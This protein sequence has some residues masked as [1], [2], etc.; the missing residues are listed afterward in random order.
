MIIKD[1]S[2]WSYIFMTSN[3]ENKFRI[4]DYQRPYVRDE[5]R[6]ED[7]LND[8]LDTENNLPFLWSFIFQTTED[9]YLD[10]V[11]GQQR[12]MSITILLSLLRNL[13][14]ELSQDKLAMSIQQR[15]TKTDN[16]WR[17][18]EFF[19]TC[20][21]DTQKFLVENILNEDW[22]MRTYNDRILKKD[23]S[24]YNIKKN[25][26]T[27]YDIILERME[28]LNDIQKAELIDHILNRLDKYQIVYIQVNNDEEAYTAFEIV[29]ARWQELWNIDLLKNLF[30]KY[31]A[32]DQNKKNMVEKRD[33]IMNNI[34]ECSAVKVNLE[35]F[36][37]HFWHARFW[38]SRF[39]S[40]K[41]LYRAFKSQISESSLWYDTFSDHMLEDSV[42]YNNMTNPDKGD[43]QFNLEYKYNQQIKA[44]LKNIKTF[45]ITQAYILLLS[46]FRYKEQ[47]GSK[48][49]RNIVLWI[50]KFHFIYSAISKL[51]GNKVEKLYGRYAESFINALN[52]DN[53]KSVSS[54]VN[55]VYD[56]LKKKFYEL[57]PSKNEFIERFIEIQYKNNNKALLR[58]IL[59]QYEQI[60]KWWYGE[61]IPDFT[62]TNIEHIFPQTNNGSMDVKDSNNIGNLMLLSISLNSECGNKSLDEKKSIY[63]KSDFAMVKE[64]VEVINS[65]AWDESKIKK[66]AKRIA[67][68]LYTEMYKHFE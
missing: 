31:A 10:I 61:T 56:S 44:Y 22:N 14:K 54:A 37:K 29:N 66:R 64:V 6:I 45:Q 2:I 65:N 17:A 15:I 49:V 38:K 41:M 47:I 23:I 67:D 50:E 32:A 62:Q 52:Q 11:D 35:S 60:L 26:N 19:L 46:I 3:I 48:K 12:I 13:S 40:S 34:N 7:F 42:L 68:I 8:L 30:F 63:M 27:L 33:K 21:E 16:F 59:T 55:V 53:E 5:E 39:I 25:Y 1:S 57:L 28:W 24:K 4:P 51:Q 9:W 18:W 58:Y 20:R 36:L 43:Y